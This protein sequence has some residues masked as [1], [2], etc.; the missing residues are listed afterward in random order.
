MHEKAIQAPLLEL[1]RA[2]PRD[3]VYVWNDVMS[4]SSYAVGRLCHDAADEIDALHATNTI[5]IANA[6]RL[7]EENERLLAA[8]RDCSASRLRLTIHSGRAR[9]TAAA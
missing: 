6:A 5:R 3:A 2:V 1:L 7:E 8:N 9:P 4:S